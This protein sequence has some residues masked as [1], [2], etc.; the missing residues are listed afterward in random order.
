M[1]YVD[2][3]L[4]GLEVLKYEKIRLRKLR[5]DDRRERNKKLNGM[6]DT[7]VMH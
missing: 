4:T 5:E 7:K 2:T 1:I 6:I 3:F